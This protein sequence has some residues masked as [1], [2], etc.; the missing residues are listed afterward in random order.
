MLGYLLQGLAL[1][2]SA[3][4]TPGPFQAYIIN[5]ALRLGWRRAF[6][7]V[8]APLIS[9]GLII[10][11]FGLTQPARGFFSSAADCRRPVCPFP[12]LEIIPGL[13]QVS[14]HSGQPAY[15][16]APECASRRPDDLSRPRTIPFLG[17]GGPLL[18]A[19]WNEQPA[20]GT[21]FLAGFDPATVK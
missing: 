11:L 18:I 9:D 2:L 15:R 7:A 8:F 17:P 1:G 3:A 21:S 12:G 6:P 14:T 19:A 10:L 4:A 13:S 20:N 16:R 5:Q